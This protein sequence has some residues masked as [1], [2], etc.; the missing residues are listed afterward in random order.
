MP[1]KL[2]ELTSN[3]PISLLHIVSKVFEK[4]LLKR[5]FSMVENNR[6]IPDHQ[7][8]FRQRH[9]TMEHTH[10]NVQSI[11]EALE[12]KQYFFAAF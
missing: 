11:N 5:V 6:I 1:G 8:G 2:N 3:R 7:L 12:N 10:R 4:L 9:S